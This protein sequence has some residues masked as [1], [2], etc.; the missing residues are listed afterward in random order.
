V[1]IRCNGF[2][3]GNAINRL[4]TSTRRTIAIALTAYVYNYKAKYF[5]M[6]ILSM[7]IYIL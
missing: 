5:F 1:E 6:G 4:H 3:Q 7:I 2:G